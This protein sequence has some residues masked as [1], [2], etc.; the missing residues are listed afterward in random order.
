[1]PFVCEMNLSNLGYMLDVVYLTRRK[2]SHVHLILDSCKLGIVY[3]CN[4]IFFHNT[5][6][7]RF[8]NKA[9]I[10]HYIKLIMKSFRYMYI[11]KYIFNIHRKLC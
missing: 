9:I 11:I 6:G 8:G 5:N 1:M 10:F 4:S 3:A 7:L 2:F